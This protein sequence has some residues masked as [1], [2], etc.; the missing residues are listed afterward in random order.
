MRSRRPRPP[1]ARKPP[2]MPSS[3]A[4]TAPSIPTC[5]MIGRCPR[6]GARRP[7]RLRRC[8][9]T[10]SWCRRRRRR[11]RR[12]PRSSVRGVDANALHDAADDAGLVGHV[13]RQAAI[14]RS[15]VG[16]QLCRD[17]VGEQQ[18][19]VFAHARAPRTLIVSPMSPWAEIAT[20]APAIPS[21]PQ[22]LDQVAVVGAGVAGRWTRRRRPA[23]PS[24][25]MVLG[26][27]RKPSVDS[28]IVDQR[29]VG[30]FEQLERGLARKRLQRVRC[31]DRRHAETV[32]ARA[33]AMRGSA[34]AM[35]VLDGL[36]RSARRALRTGSMPGEDRKRRRASSQ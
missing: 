28:N 26:P 3:S 22:F 4:R 18:V 15:M 24:L 29:A 21:R 25:T 35:H 2:A 7:R 1:P 16:E 33:L 36:A 9:R 17:D 32:G 8:R 30:Q 11:G 5:K 14:E 6:H 10:P 23:C 19:A 13:G 12:A 34:V 31:R 27:W 20:T